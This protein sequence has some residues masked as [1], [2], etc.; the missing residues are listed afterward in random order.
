MHTPAAARVMCFGPFQVDARTRELRKRGTRLRVPEQSVRVLLALLDRAGDVVTRDELTAILWPT[1]TAVDVE[2]GLNSAV[3]RL[4]D[5]LGDS[6]ERPV[7]IETVPRVGYRF[8]GSVD[9]PLAAATDNAASTETPLAEV[10]CVSDQQAESAPARTGFRRQRQRRLVITTIVVLATMASMIVW[11]G[12]RTERVIATSSPEPIPLTFEDGL[13]TD[14]SFSVDGQWI[15]YTS[16]SGGNFDIWIRRLSGGDPVKVTHDEADDSQ[17][18]WSPDGSRLVFRSERAGGGLFVVPVTGGGA[19]RIS[20]LGFRPRWSPDGRQILF[21]E[22]LLTGLDLNLHVID[23]GSGAAHRWPGDAR[24]AFGWQPRS[25]TVLQL[26]SLYGPFEPTLASWQVG[27]ASVTRWTIDGD[28]M[29]GFQ[30]H[31]LVVIGGE[32]VMPSPGMSLLYF[33]GASRGRRALWRIDLD[34]AAR[35]VASGPHRVTTLPDVNNATLSPDGTRVVFDGSARHAQIV[36]YALDPEDAS[37]AGPTAMTPEAIHAHSPTLSRN[38]RAFAFVLTR[39]GSPDRSEITARLPGH[40]RDLAIRAIDHPREVV[41]TP[42]WNA[43]GTKL[44]Y[45]LVVNADQPSS[46]RQQ[47]RLFDA[48]SGEDVPLTSPHSPVDRVELSTG[49]TPDGRHLIVTSQYATGRHEIALVPIHAAPQAERSR[50]PVTSSAKGSVSAAVMSPDARWIAFRVGQRDGL[51]ARIAVVSSAGGE[52][53]DWTYVTTGAE[54]ADKPC[55]SDDGTTLY[56]TSGNDSVNV[57][58]IGLDTLRGRPVGQPFQITKFKGPGEHILS[59]IRTLAI[60]T[61]GKRLVVPV[62][63]PK[64]GLWMLELGVH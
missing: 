24:G 18:D 11:R 21:A 48:A 46:A 12:R 50:Q 49:W 63:R 64:G 36:S 62:V 54:A 27:S 40:S 57:W 35:R 5:A 60:G 17:P 53:Q 56:F 10:P 45:S 29:R 14:P 22:Q 55:W 28:V 37:H 41:H 7:Y 43:D 44:A 3:R 47:L 16:N 59:D 4:R 6:A 15:A 61:C 38:G 34:P 32:E 20:S 52:A 42:R 8:V 9:T 58:G 25:S 13:Q 2:H 51:A 1:A 26:G 30:A 31:Q 19:Q 33:V 39:P 23:V